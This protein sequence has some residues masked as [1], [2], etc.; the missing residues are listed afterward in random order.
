VE[1]SLFPLKQQLISN[2]EKLQRL[3]STMAAMPKKEYAT[4]EAKCRALRAARTE[5]LDRLDELI[6][7]SENGALNQEWSDDI[8]AGE[9]II[10]HSPSIPFLVTPV[11][12]SF[13]GRGSF[14]FS[15]D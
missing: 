15:R 13:R 14:K 2:Y 11:S 8:K 3:Q 9:E 10:V 5:A 4:T 12:C 6:S 7:S 1:E